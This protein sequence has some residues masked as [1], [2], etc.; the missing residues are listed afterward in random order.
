MAAYNKFHDFGY[1]LLHA[2]IDCS[3]D[4]LKMYLAATAPSQS[5]DAGK[6]NLASITATGG[7]TTVGGLDTVNTLAEDTTSGVWKVGCTSSLVWTAATASGT[8]PS[9]RYV[10]LYDDTTN[11]AT[12]D[13]YTDQLIAWWDYGSSVWG[14]APGNGDTFTVTCTGSKLF[15]INSNS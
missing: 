9:F 4:T 8:F 2:E 1:S 3:A 6:A 11:T 13:T 15:T 14:T 7:Y 12:G 10:V 5:A